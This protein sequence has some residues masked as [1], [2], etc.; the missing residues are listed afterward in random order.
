[1]TVTVPER[2]QLQRN[3][4][5]TRL[6][7]YLNTKFKPLYILIMKQN[8]VKKTSTEQS[9]KF[10]R[11]PSQWLPDTSRCRCWNKQRFDS[12]PSAFA[13]DRQELPC[14]SCSHDSRWLGRTHLCSVQQQS[15]VWHL[16]STT[17]ARGTECHSQMDKAWQ[18]MKEKFYR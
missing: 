15:H 6:T 11:S 4:L 9:I 2:C 7:L 14:Q 17:T 8:L 10:N 18:G 16:K 12:G 1:M 5:K 3:T 13:G